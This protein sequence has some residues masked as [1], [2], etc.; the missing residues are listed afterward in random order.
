[1]VI[2]LTFLVLLV[3]SGCQSGIIPCP[4][5]KVAKVKKSKPYRPSPTSFS[6]RAEVESETLHN[7]TNKTDDDRSFKNISVEEWDCPR[8][9]EKKYM[10]KNV[11]DNIRRN[12][13]KINS[14]SKTTVDSLRTK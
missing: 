8:P 4:T 1:M 10:P 3:C 6:A 14:S 13:K 12:M 7:K 5:V 2:R 9:G 11:K